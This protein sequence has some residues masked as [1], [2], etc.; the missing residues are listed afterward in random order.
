M[1]EAS[2]IFK[3]LRSLGVARDDKSIVIQMY[4]GMFCDI[5]HMLFFFSTETSPVPCSD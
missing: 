4:S 2:T 5:F 3:Q 1:F